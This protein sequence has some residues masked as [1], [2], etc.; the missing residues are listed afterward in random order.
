M[1]EHDETHSTQEIV[2]QCDC[3]N[4]NGKP[5]KLY[6]SRREAQSIKKLRE[7][8]IGKK[9]SIYPCPNFLGKFHLTKEQKNKR[10]KVEGVYELLDKLQ[11]T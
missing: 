10:K 7:K 3:T 4:R 5:K 11:A 6:T 9:L 1:I 2:L 8:E